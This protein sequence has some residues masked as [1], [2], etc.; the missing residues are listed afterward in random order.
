MG[1]GPRDWSSSQL[2]SPG[3]KVKP[4]STTRFMTVSSDLGQRRVLEEALEFAPGF[5]LDLADAFAR[6]FVLSAHFLQGAREAVVQAVAEF[7]DPALALGEA[8][9]HFAQ[10]AP[11][12]VKA[13]DIARVL[14]GLVL[15]EV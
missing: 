1:Q 12:Q 7:Q 14:G 11:E 10:L 6:D 4:S 9:Q 8:M 15:D 2:K 3:F 13:R 5:G